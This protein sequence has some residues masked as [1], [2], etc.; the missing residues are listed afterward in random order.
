MNQLDTRIAKLSNQLKKPDCSPEICDQMGDFLQV[1]AEDLVSL[2]EGL[3]EV[4]KV[5]QE[6]AEY[7]C[8]DPNTFK[9]EEC[10]KIILSFCNR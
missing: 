8:E 3:E 1:A 5:K 9:M 7:F 10:F 6:V 2:K 4:D